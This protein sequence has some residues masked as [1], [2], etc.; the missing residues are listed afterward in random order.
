MIKRK[1][2]YWLTLVGIVLVTGSLSSPSIVMAKSRLDQ[3]KIIAVLT[4]EF[5]AVYVFPETAKKMEDALK[6]NLAEGRYKSIDDP[7]ILAQRLK[8]DMIAVSH[9]KHI[10]IIYM[11][12][13][14]GNPEQSP[15]AE[16]KEVAEMAENNFGFKK[17][18]ILQGNIGYIDLRGFMPAEYGGATAVAAMKYMAN[19]RALI[20]DLRNNGGGSPSMIQ[21]LTSY[22]LAK[23]THLNSF[24]VRRTDSEQQF[25]TPS[26]VDGPRYL[27][28]E[29]YILTSDR[30]FSAAE[31]FTNNLK[32]LKRATIVGETTGGGAHPVDFHYFKDI[33]F[34]AMIPFGRAINPISKTNWEG[35]GIDPDVKVS[36]EQALST[37]HR[38]ALQNLLKTTKDAADKKRIG[39]ALESLK[40]VHSPLTLKAE[41]L[42]SYVGQY[43]DRII[44]LENDQLVYTRGT[45]KNR[46]IPLDSDR[47][48]VEG[49]DHFRVQFNR[50][51][52]GDLVS[53]SGLYE[54]GRTDKAE[55]SK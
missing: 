52:K 10:N 16:A 34:A 44:A 46:L 27:N 29:V 49:L 24:Y 33:K 25:W 1:P 41:T 17:L 23:A 11:E 4:R 5:N 53:L 7:E 43:G 9:D 19:T 12:K 26:H 2:S 51:G 38:M 35:T 32:N 31:E 39:W 37:A 21:L 13:E 15:E 50:D 55:R 8:E 6:K 54:N 3:A 14:P 36:Q 20:F 30:T 18:E 47:F 48:A 28:K 42:K 40:A 22:L 45:R